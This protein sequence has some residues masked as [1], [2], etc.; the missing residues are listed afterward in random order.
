M[1][2]KEIKAGMNNISLEGKI[3]EKSKEK[4]VLTRYGE[5][6]VA[7]VIIEDETG[8]IKASLWEDQIDKINVGDNVKISNAYSTE[9]K[10]EVQINIPKK[11]KIEKV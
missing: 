1:K 5:R 3:V 11:G 2:V 9:F 8:K 6:R 4:T 10:N 7:E